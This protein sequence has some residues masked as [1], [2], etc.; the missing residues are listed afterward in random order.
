[1]CIRVHREQTFYWKQYYALWSIRL[2][3]SSSALFKPSTKE[4]EARAG[5]TTACLVKHS[6][7]NCC[8]HAL[9]KAR[10]SGAQTPKSECRIANIWNE[11]QLN[12]LNQMDEWPASNIEMGNNAR[13]PLFERE[14]Y[15]E[16]N[17]RI[18]CI[19]HIMN[20]VRARTS[21]IACSIINVDAVDPLE[22]ISCIQH[23]ISRRDESRLQKYTYKV[24]PVKA[25]YRKL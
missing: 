1:M 22:A 25:S 10:L 24:F 20:P 18:T 21:F 17:V 23:D 5:L 12:V 7:S 14:S 16:D 2:H 19:N 3:D 6:H 13:T 11:I 9:A 8:L 15:I 4:D